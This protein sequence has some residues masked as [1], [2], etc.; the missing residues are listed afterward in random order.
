MGQWDSLLFCGLLMQG[1]EDLLLAHYDNPLVWAICEI[2]ALS[3]ISIYLEAYIIST[4][5]LQ[6]R[7]KNQV[8]HS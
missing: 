3:K 5:L 7:I 8:K 6:T 1:I 4:I 2:Q